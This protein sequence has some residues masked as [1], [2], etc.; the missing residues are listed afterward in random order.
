MD[1]FA[2]E[3]KLPE[4]F[5]IPIPGLLP[6]VIPP[7]EINFPPRMI[8]DPH[9]D[10][11]DF[12]KS[13]KACRF[14]VA[15]EWGDISHYVRAV[16]Y[17]LKPQEIT[18]VLNDLRIP[19][20]E[21]DLFNWVNKLLYGKD[22]IT[23]TVLGNDLIPAYENEFLGCRLK[24]HSCPMD[25]ASSDVATHHVTVTYDHVN[26]NHIKRKESDA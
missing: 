3:T 15:S 12:D 7:P 25:Y 10:P 20:R 17:K 21:N 4:S 1:E 2:P 22:N 6:I 16:T 19:T 24:E 8:G 9:M 26:I 23:V 13:L 5:V 14:D 11:K 18:F